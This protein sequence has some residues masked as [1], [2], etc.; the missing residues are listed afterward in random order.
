VPVHFKNEELSPGMKAGGALTINLHEVQLEVPADQIPEELV[1][2]LEGLEMGAVIHAS[3]LKLPAG[4]KVSKHDAELTVASIAMSS[5]F[6]SDEAAT[7]ET[8]EG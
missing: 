4:A 8:A 7:T 6:K 5:A 1:V 2:D 3:D